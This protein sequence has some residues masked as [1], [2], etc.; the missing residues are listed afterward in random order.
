MRAVMSGYALR[1]NPTYD[2]MQKFT[3]TAIEKSHQSV[4]GEPVEPH[5]IQQAQGERFFV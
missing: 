5:T 4:R 3:L 2:L 1:A